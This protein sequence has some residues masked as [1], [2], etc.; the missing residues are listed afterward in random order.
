MR[1][2]ALRVG[3]LK[4]A[5]VIAPVLP[6]IGRFKT[7]TEP[8]LQGYPFMDANRKIW[9]STCRAATSGRHLFIHPS[10][11]PE[12]SPGPIN[13]LQGD[14]R[15]RRPIEPGIRRVGFTLIV[16]VFTTPRPPR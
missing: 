16:D 11:S 1:T 3:D 13:L 8:K 15:S 5:R 9:G 7:S 14:F 4:V 2:V 10:A 6:Y 12:A